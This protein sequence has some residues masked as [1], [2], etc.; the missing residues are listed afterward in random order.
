MLRRTFLATPLAALAARTPR[1]TAEELAAV[2]GQE[3]TDIVYTQTVSL[4][5][6]LRLGQQ[7]EVMRILEPWLSGA[8]DSLAKPTASHY[9]GHLIFGSINDPRAKALLTKAA[10]K[11][12]LDPLDSEM[13]DSVFMVCPLLA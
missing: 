6:R 5:G 12:S 3:I 8:K 10:G 2:Y 11:A 4:I 7:D 13:S 1:Q 9:S